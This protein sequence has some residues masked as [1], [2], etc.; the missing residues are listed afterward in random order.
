MPS[1]TAP[2]NQESGIE[3]L[4]FGVTMSRRFDEFSILD[5]SNSQS[6]AAPLFFHRPEQIV[7]RQ[8][9]EL[10]EFVRGGDLGKLGA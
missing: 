6:T 4:E 7:R 1:C 10:P 5:S 2:R 9:Q 3:N 8:R